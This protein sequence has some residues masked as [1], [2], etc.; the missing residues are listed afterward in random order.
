MVD[1]KD[2]T[3][4][5]QQRQLVTAQERAKEY[6]R[7]LPELASNKLALQDELQTTKQTLEEKNSTL[8]QARKQLKSTRDRNMVGVGIKAGSI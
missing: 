1:A 4:S 3:I 8:A 2:S 7:Q 6:E 5:T